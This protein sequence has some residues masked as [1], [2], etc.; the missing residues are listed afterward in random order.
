MYLFVG[1]VSQLRSLESVESKD[2]FFARAESL[3]LSFLGLILGPGMFE[4]TFLTGMG[5]FVLEGPGSLED[6]TETLFWGE[7]D[8]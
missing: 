5:G 2:F 7:L 6:D 3:R 4:A 8:L 1:L